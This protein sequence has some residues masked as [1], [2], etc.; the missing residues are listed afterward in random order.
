MTHI[1][2]RQLTP[3]TR[4]LITNVRDYRGGGTSDYRP[5]RNPRRTSYQNAPGELA[6]IIAAT[7]TAVTPP[8]AGSR[9]WTIRTNAATITGVVAAQRW[10]SAPDD[11]TDHADDMARI[12]AATEAAAADRAADRTS[13][14]DIDGTPTNI[15]DVVELL[16]Q[17]GGG[18]LGHPWAVATV[19]D[20]TIMGVWYDL[21][22]D[23]R[24]SPRRQWRRLVPLA[25]GNDGTAA[26]RSCLC[27]AQLGT[28]TVHQHFC[29]WY[30]DRDRG[31]P[32]PAF[33]P[34]PDAVATID[35]AAD[36]RAASAAGVS[37]THRRDRIQSFA[38]TRPRCSAPVGVGCRTP[39]GYLA[40]FHRERVA[41]AYP[42]T[43]PVRARKHRLTD[44]QAAWI[45]LAAEGDQ[46]RMYAPDQYATLGG[47]AARRQTADAL[48]AAGLFN[49]VDTTT[50]GERV[51]ELTDAGWSTYWTHR[52]VI[53]RGTPD[54]PDTCPCVTT[55]PARTAAA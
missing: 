38:C 19:M 29:D 18:R 22:D 52:L 28:L 24:L 42:S 12:A 34:H 9:H 14:R 35:P 7:V 6:G 1:T 16:H 45:E 37:F 25:V 40:Q 20:I 50:D 49:V 36:I 53:R 44:P 15:G 48:I 4:V 21:D 13:P 5:A 41:L 51:L 8:A 46:H 32:V 23:R 27:P 43:K 26:I 11:M 17:G 2:T 3:G 54:H 55:D 31:V 30:S 10:R 33:T 39:N 47:D